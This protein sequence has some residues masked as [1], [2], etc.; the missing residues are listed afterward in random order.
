MKTALW[1]EGAL[2]IHYERRRQRQMADIETWVAAA[3]DRLRKYEKERGVSGIRQP[4]NRGQGV[5][6]A[7]ERGAGRELGTMANK[8]PPV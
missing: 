2:S 8:V 3:K 6:I 1:M 7:N 4:V 5:V